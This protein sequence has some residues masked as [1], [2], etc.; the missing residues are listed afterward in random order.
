MEPMLYPDWKEK[1]VYSDTGPQPTILVETEKLRAVV[2]G[3]EP[4]T[5]IPPHADKG[6]AMFHFLQGN[7]WMSVNEERFAVTAGATVIAPEGAVRGMTADTR[8]S[9]LVARVAP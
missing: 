6:V 3:L 8:L 1:V 4:G 5:Q 7:G 2:V 9:F